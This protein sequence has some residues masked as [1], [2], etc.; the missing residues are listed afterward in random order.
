VKF[1]LRNKWNKWGYMKLKSFCIANLG[2]NLTKEVKDL[3]NENYKSL[4]S[5]TEGDIRRW[6]DLPGS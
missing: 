6:K 4:K 1:I 5:G 3:N 2:I